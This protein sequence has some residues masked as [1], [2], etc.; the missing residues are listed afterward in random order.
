MK[1]K[2]GAMFKDKKNINSFSD[3]DLWQNSFMPADYLCLLVGNA[4]NSKDTS[5][6]PFET[7]GYRS[8]TTNENKPIY[9]QNS[10]R[11]EENKEQI[12]S[13]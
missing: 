13:I 10:I 11:V 2:E 5:T 12:L 4:F 3:A 7:I 8:D 1:A 6:T 9:H